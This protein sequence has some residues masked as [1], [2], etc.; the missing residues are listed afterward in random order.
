MIKIN[1]L[2]EKVDN[3]ALYL[4]QLFIGAMLILLTIAV[5]VVIHDGS[6]NKVEGLKAEKLLLERR[7]SQ[8][9]KKTKEV[10]DLERKRKLLREKLQTIAVLKAKKHGPVHI[11]DDLNTALPERSWLRSLKQKGGTLE[12][13]GVA[14][15]EQTIAN[16]MNQLKTRPL[17]S[18]VDL[19]LSTEFA[20]DQV[21]LKE[22]TLSIPLKSPIENMTG[23]P[24]APAQKATAEKKS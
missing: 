20:R 17:F 6:R 13:K 1:L 9:E 8:L 3:T 21:K 16:Y 5:C 14:L 2:G 18:S 12:V 7:L 22:F 19:V 15:D 4:L 23:A 11:L 24:V 10:E